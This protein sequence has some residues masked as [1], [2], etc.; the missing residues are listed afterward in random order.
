M[1]FKPMWLNFNMMFMFFIGFFQCRWFDG[2][3]HGKTVERPFT[4][5]LITWTI[6]V[7]G[8]V[9]M[10]L[11]CSHMNWEFLIIP[12]DEL[13]FFR[14]FFSTTNQICL[15]WLNGLV[16]TIGCYF[17]KTVWLGWCFSRPI[18]NP[19]F[20]ESRGNTFYCC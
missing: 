6:L 19:S 1:G 2:F 4:M 7:G 15:H 9:A 8:L 11:T 18:E 16:A 3:F 14:G 5:G 10:N 12:I 20:G 17:G 13:I